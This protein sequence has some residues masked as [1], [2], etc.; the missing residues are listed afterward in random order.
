MISDKIFYTINK[1]LVFIAGAYI[2]FWPPFTLTG[3]LSSI[4]MMIAAA[5]SVYAIWSNKPDVEFVSLWFVICG[6]GTYAGYT[7]ISGEFFVRSII[8]SMLL[9]M[10]IARGSMLWRLIRQNYTLGRLERKW[11]SN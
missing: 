1:L 10:L 8:A 2:V 3:T 4:V 6:I 9:V 5:I 11:H 7:Y